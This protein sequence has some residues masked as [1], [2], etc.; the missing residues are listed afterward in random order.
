MVP[1]KMLI[2]VMPPAMIAGT[3]RIQKRRTSASKRGS[4]SFGTKP[5]R[6]IAQ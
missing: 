2:W 3:A 1:T 4:L 5:A 6:R